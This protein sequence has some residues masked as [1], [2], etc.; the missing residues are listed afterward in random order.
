MKKSSYK[1]PI[2][3]ILYVIEIIK[4]SNIKLDIKEIFVMNEKNTLENLFNKE[5]PKTLEL[6]IWREYNSI[7]SFFV[8]D[9]C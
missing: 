1:T 5:I 9:N 6:E 4:R 8:E 7:D 2:R 3:I